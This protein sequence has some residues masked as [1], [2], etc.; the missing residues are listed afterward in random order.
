MTV[1]VAAGIA[2]EGWGWDG[3]GVG[4]GDVAVVVGM[5][6]VVVVMFSMCEDVGRRKASRSLDALICARWGAHPVLSDHRKLEGR[7]FFNLLYDYVAL[8]FSLVC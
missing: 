7:L 1:A 3:D 5:V 6:G 2:W 8:F 4:L